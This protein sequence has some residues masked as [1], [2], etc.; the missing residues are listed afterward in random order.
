[1]DQPKTRLISTLNR[2]QVICFYEVAGVASYFNN[3]HYWCK[4]SISRPSPEEQWRSGTHPTS[5]PIAKIR[6]QRP[7][8]KPTP[9]IQKSRQNGSTIVVR[10][11]PRRLSHHL[12]RRHKQHHNEPPQRQPHPLNP[13]R[14]TWRTASPTANQW[15]RVL[16]TYWSDKRPCWPPPNINTSY[17]NNNRTDLTQETAKSRTGWHLSEIA[18]AE[19]FRT[20]L[21]WNH[22]KQRLQ[23]V[24][25]SKQKA[26]TETIKK[27]TREATGSETTTA[28]RRIPLNRLVVVV[29]EAWAQNYCPSLKQLYTNKEL[30]FIVPVFTLVLCYILLRTGLHCPGLFSPI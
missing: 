18:S 6:N 22:H 7:W 20:T 12:A 13:D 30:D 3:P 15:N 11:Q 26:K 21:A 25:S 23:P 2:F 9:E 17:W 14:T 29:V 4:F 24:R 8:C 28:R 19:F 1:M 10:Y 16:S 5:W 27:A